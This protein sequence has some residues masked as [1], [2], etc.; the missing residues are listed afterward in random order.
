MGRFW[1]P[2]LLTVWGSLLRLGVQCQTSSSNFPTAIAGT[3]RGALPGRRGARCTSR[4]TCRVGPLYD[5]P[6]A[7]DG[8]EETVAVFVFNGTNGTGVRAPGGYK[9]TLLDTYFRQ[10]LK[11]KKPQFTDVVAMGPGNDP[12]DGT[13]P[14]DVSTEVYLDPC[15]VGSLA[16]RAKIA[17]YFNELT[18]QGWVDAVST[19]RRPPCGTPPSCPSA[20][21]TP[22]TEAAAHGRRWRSPR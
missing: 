15:L 7:F 16:Q 14:Y 10:V 4:R 13:S 8:T 1:G 21:E 3:G 12:G 6:A 2:T 11:L 20:T 18:E 9:A 5:F 19:P 17:V 22:R